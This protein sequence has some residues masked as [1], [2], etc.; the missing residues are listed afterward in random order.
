MEWNKYVICITK[1][2]GFN[3]VYINEWVLHSI[4]LWDLQIVYHQYIEQY[5]VESQ[6]LL[7]HD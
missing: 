1:H 3:S 2:P 5:R 7:V 4:G 6:P